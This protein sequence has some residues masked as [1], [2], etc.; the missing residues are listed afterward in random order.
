M[1]IGLNSCGCEADVGVVVF[2]SCGCE[3]G[4]EVVVLGCEAG[5]GVVVLNCCK[6]D[7]YCARICDSV[8]SSVDALAFFLTHLSSRTSFLAV[9]VTNVYSV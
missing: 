7:M 6:V 5:M 9:Y 1:R 8:S 3:A 4:V 2:I